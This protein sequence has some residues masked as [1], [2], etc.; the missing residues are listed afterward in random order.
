MSGKTIPVVRLSELPLESWTQGS[1]Y[2]G[3]DA[4]RIGEKSGLKALGFGY[5]EVPPGKSGC[6][7]HNHHVEDEMFVVLEGEGTYRFGQESFAFKAG[8]VLVAPAG[9]QDTAHQIINTGTVMLKFIAISNKSAIEVCEYPDSGKFLVSSLA[10]GTGPK[11]RHMG[12]QGKHHIEDYWD[13]ED[14]AKARSAIQTG[15]VT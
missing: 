14:G 3:H 5:S 12:R 7:F 15:D 1:L 9:G 4:N 2:A 8:D 10:G 11:L 6:P 13:G